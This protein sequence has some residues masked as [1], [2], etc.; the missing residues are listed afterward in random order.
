MFYCHVQVALRVR[1]MNHAEFKNGAKLIAHTVDNNVSYYKLLIYIH[2]IIT[3]T[4]TI[5]LHMN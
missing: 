3:C 4:L 2:Y 5:S 1:P